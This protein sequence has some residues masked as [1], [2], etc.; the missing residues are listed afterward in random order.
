MD[1]IKPSDDDS[2]AESS[3]ARSSYHAFVTMQVTEEIE[4]EETYI[5]NAH[6]L[7]CR[8]YCIRLRLTDPATYPPDAGISFEQVLPPPLQPAHLI[9]ADRHILHVMYQGDCFGGPNRR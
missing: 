2:S 5:M 9:A 3:S 6:G 1:I 8:E 7:P 4:V